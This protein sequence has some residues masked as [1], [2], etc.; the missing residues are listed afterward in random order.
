VERIPKGAMVQDL[1]ESSDS[2]SSNASRRASGEFLIATPSSS[3]SLLEAILDEAENDVH[4]SQMDCRASGVLVR[5]GID[6]SDDEDDG[7]SLEEARLAEMASKL[8]ELEQ[9]TPQ[10]Y[11]DAR[12]SVGR[13]KKAAL[14][15]RPLKEAPQTRPL[16][17]PFV[18]L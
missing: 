12:G 11:A 16:M 5:R 2:L 3:W 4:Q 18:P 15:K 1:C 9:D 13:A 8:A 14:Q 7:L 17:P 10:A 6:M